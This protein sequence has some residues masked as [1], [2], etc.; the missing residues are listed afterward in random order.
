MFVNYTRIGTVG[1]SKSYFVDVIFIFF[2]NSSEFWSHVK[3][4]YM[5]GPDKYKE[6]HGHPFHRRRF[7]DCKIPGCKS[8][9][10]WDRAKLMTHF[11]R[12]HKNITMRSYY[13]GYVQRGSNDTFLNLLIPNKAT[14]VMVVSKTLS[15]LRPLF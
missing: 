10:D 14:P 15:V 3:K 12:R 2:H 13:E 5:I 1:T 8:K 6:R 7:H 9:V 11:F 4:D